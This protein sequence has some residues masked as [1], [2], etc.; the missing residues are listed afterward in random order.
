MTNSLTGQVLG[1]WFSLIVKSYITTQFNYNYRSL[2]SGKA[3]KHIRSVPM[4]HLSQHVQ[5][6]G[7]VSWLWSRRRWTGN[8][9]KCGRILN[10][11]ATIIVSPESSP[12]GNLTY[13][14]PVNGLH[15]AEQQFQ[16]LHR[17]TVTRQHAQHFN[18]QI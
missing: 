6:L 7:R 18:Q 13:P 9:G 8:R 5:Q 12:N 15:G 3:E 14:F 1:K 17:D 16:L 2:P 10:Y 11:P 4:R